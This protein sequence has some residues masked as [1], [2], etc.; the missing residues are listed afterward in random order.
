[1]S[2]LIDTVSDR[3]GHFFANQIFCFDNIAVNCCSAVEQFVFCHC[4]GRAIIAHIQDRTGLLH[5]VQLVV[6]HQRFKG[7][8][9]TIATFPIQVKRSLDLADSMQLRRK[10]L[11]I[12]AV[13]DCV[14]YG[15]HLHDLR[16]TP[17]ARREEECDRAVDI[18][19]SACR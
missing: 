18:I 6:K 9:G 13:I 17:V 16:Q 19:H 8:D 11:G 5:I 1:M 14:V 3:H 7:K 2:N 4:N 12:V 10:N 15:C